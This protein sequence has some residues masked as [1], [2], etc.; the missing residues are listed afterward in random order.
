LCAIVREHA[1]SILLKTLDQ[2][3]G[4]GTTD[5]PALA[6]AARQTSARAIVRA[7]VAAEVARYNETEEPSGLVGWLAPPEP[8][9]VLNGPRRER[10]RP[11]DVER[12]VEVAFEAIRRR[13]VV[14]LF[15]GAQVEDLDAPLTITPVSEARFLRL[16]PLVG[17]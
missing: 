17:G 2:V 8:E 4:V 13:R 5:G 14:L 9:L 16:V 15:N 6:F 10:R 11:L 12:Q 3:P 1:M 7:R